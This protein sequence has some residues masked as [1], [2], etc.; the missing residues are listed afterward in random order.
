MAGMTYEKL[1]KRNI[2]DFGERPEHGIAYY[3]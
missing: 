2:G 3:A 1:C